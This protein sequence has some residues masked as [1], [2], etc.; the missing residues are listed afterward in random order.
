V[1]EL[2][3]APPA[4]AIDWPAIESVVDP[5]LLSATPPGP[6]YQAEGAVWT[7]TRMVV[8]AMAASPAWRALD[9]DARAITFAG[10]LLHD[11]GKPSTT[12]T[13]PDGRITSRGHSARGE[14][15]VRQMLWR[16]G[17]PFGVREHVAGLVRC[18]QVP[19]FLIEQE[20]AAARQALARLSLALRCD[21]LALV[22]EADAR[23][24]RCRDPRDQQTILDRTALFVE[25]AAEAGVLDRAWRF[26][27]DHTRF[28]SLRDVRRP[29]DVPVHDDTRAEVIVMSGLPGAGKD[30]WLA[31]HHPELPVV[32]LDDIRAEL[33]VDPADGQSAVI[34]AARERAR[35]HMRRGEPFAWNAT[36][37]SRRLRASLV[38]FLTGYPV[39]V[40][41]VYLEVAAGEQERRNRER[42]SVVP[43]A[44][45]ARILD[46][47]AP[48][49]PDE[50]HRVTH[51]VDGDERGPISWPPG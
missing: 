48:P 18:H 22:A 13:E 12:R 43:R 26:P 29:P 11:L 6:D 24:R 35:E 37:V 7:H 16:A 51:V 44:A 19:F 50:A 25:L 1:K 45:M 38:D 41:L 49:S 27:S 36:N 31:A 3:P 14:S 33:E 4:F 34:A 2:A 23:G 46:R 10:A 9:D 39:R 17:V 40:H 32:A 15:I 5:E 47:W 42:E 8:E 20:P 28:V 21:W 30:A